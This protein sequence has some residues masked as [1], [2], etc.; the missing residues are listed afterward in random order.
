MI[1]SCFKKGLNNYIEKNVIVHKNVIIGNNNKIFD[2]TIL[3]PNTVIGDNN[4]ILNGNTIGEHPV[5]ANEDIENFRK[6]FDN[7]VIIGNNNF[8][9][10]NNIIFSGVD[11]PTKIGNYNKLLAENHI[12][13]DTNIE[14]YVTIYP[15]CITGGFSKIMSNSSMG[16][17]STI[18]QK[19]KIGNYSM[20][21]AGNNA[22]KDIFPFYIQINNKYIRPNNHKIPAFLN[23]NKYDKE[24]RIIA[25]RYRN[26]DD[27]ILK[28]IWL[29]NNIMKIIEN[30]KNI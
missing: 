24:I 17:Y 2:G 29:P 23:I 4:V 10:I 6:S 9:H 12:G 19:K 1:S 16:F 30:F 14:N 20:L 5:N 25:E 21:A 22:S 8:F 26:D 15:R 28:N 18:Q 13:H 3:Y 27:D 7:G 11:S